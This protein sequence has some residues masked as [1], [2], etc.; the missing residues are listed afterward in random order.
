MIHSL[1]S[2]AITKIIAWRNPQGHEE[3]WLQREG[4]YRKLPSLKKII[5][6]ELLFA[7]LSIT[8]LIETI[9][10]SVLTFCCLPLDFISIQ[11]P[12][13]FTAGWLKS[14]CFSIL[15]SMSNLFHNIVAPNLLTQESTARRFAFHGGLRR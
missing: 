8:A 6:S 11:R 5:A 14:A 9:A 13:V 15:W 2:R 3:R 4:R 1:S 10:A 12:L 7:L